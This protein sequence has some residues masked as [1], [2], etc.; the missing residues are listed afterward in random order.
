MLRHMQ[1]YFW[2]IYK[3][4]KVRL[5]WPHCHNNLIRK[6]VSN[7]GGQTSLGC[8]IGRAC[9]SATMYCLLY[10]QCTFMHCYFLV[11]VLGCLH[12]H[13]RVV[14]VACMHY[15]CCIYKLHLHGTNL[16]FKCDTFTT[17]LSFDLYQ[18]FSFTCSWIVRMWSSIVFVLL[19]L[20]QQL[21][22]PLCCGT[23]Q[24]AIWS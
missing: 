19:C 4:Y 14:F 1:Y 13:V 20:E 10:L 15:V 7:W 3:R 9:A 21:G 12:L 17:Y 18:I 6:D 23:F 11:S 22:I 8:G 5:C 16:E 2:L 24:G